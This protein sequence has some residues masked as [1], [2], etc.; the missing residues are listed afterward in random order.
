MLYRIKNSDQSG[1]PDQLNESMRDTNRGGYLWSQTTQTGNTL[2]CLGAFVSK[3]Y[4]CFIF[5]FEIVSTHCFLSLLHD[6]QHLRKQQPK[7][8]IMEYPAYPPR[9]SKE[10]ADF[11]NATAIDWSLGNGLAMLSPEGK[12]VTAVHAPI[13]V[14]PSPFPKSAMA[15]ALAVQTAF[16]ELYVR[17]ADNEKW[18]EES[19]TEYV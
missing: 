13:T 1:L 7:E 19:L 18:L 15:N 9:P 14:Y 3:I 8:T 11:I 2:T 4:F 10:E 16:N 12:G 6:Y 17:V 5:R